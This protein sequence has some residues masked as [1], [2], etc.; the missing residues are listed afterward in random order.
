MPMKNPNHPGDLIRDCL[1]ELGVN[2]RLSDPT[3]ARNVTLPLVKAGK[4]KALAVT[5]LER[6]GIV[7]SENGSGS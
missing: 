6:G 3:L 5:S 7:V 4:I 2:V 1:E